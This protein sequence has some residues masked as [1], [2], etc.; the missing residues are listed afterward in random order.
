MLLSVADVFATSLQDLAVPAK[1]DKFSIDTSDAL[2]IKQKPFKMGK[3][4]VEF[5]NTTILGQLK[6]DIVRHSSSPWSSPAFVAYARP[7]WSTA[8]PKARKVID[9][10]RVNRVTRS[11][12]YPLP[13]I[14]ALLE[15]L[16]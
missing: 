2:P 15:W 13:D 5:L 7:Y 3:R 6:A 9:Y 11:D 1:G 14:P 10:R 12:T 16:S 4:E 8:P